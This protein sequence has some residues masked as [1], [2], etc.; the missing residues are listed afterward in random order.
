M[1]LSD[2]QYDLPQEL[3]AQF[4]LED[5][6]AARMLV[7]DRQ[8]GALT[9]STFNRITDFAKKGD[10]FVL[11]NTRVFKAR[12]VGHKRTGGKVEVL[13]IRKREG[14]LWE[15]MISHAKRIHA[16]T[17]IEFAEGVTARI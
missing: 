14:S 9:H 4:P 15:A 2:F 1:K 7:L 10:V 5:R 17:E 3:I 16:K 13:L 11:N 8:T 6:V 12:L